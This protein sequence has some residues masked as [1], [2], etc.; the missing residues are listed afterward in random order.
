MD[1][2]GLSGRTLA[3]RHGYSRSRIQAWLAGHSVPSVQTAT[4]LA[5]QLFWP[6]L[7]RLAED[8]RRLTCAECGAAFIVDHASPARYCS[9]ECKLVHAKLAAGS[10]DLTRAVLERRVARYR[11]AVR[12]MCIQCEPSGTC[13]TATCALQVA[14]VSSHPVTR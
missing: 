11:S 7:Q 9:R 3:A 4:L 12:L 6:G 13:H 5:D 8:A 14:G 1:A 2:K 10:R